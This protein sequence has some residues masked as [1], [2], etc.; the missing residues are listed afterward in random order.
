MARAND[1]EEMMRLELLDPRTEEEE[2]EYLEMQKRQTRQ[3]GIRSLVGD[4]SGMTINQCVQRCW[5]KSFDY[6]GLQ[7]GQLQRRS[8]RQLG[9]GG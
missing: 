3:S 6:A 4:F 1:T 7:V 2:Y 8:H 9:Q 5:A